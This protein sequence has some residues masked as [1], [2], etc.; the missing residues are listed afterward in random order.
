MK[1]FIPLLFCS[2]FALWSCKL[3]DTFTQTNV[4]DLVTFHEGQLIN[5]YGYPLNVVQDAVGS[6]KWQIPEARFYVIYDILN[7]QLDIYLKELVRSTIL[8]P[9]AYNEEVEYAKDPLVP[10]MAGYS[11]GYLNLGFN[12]YRAK[13]S[14]NAHPIYFYSEVKNS[15]LYIHVVHEG[16]NEDPVHMAEGDLEGQSGVFSLNL[17]NVPEYTQ[18]TLIV[19]CLETKSDGTYEII[20]ET[21][22]I[23]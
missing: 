12:Y 6:S 4:Q 11:G 20:E 3:E 7:R 16:N 9:L 23:K 8:E 5:D 2:L 10:V 19:Q 14:N 15:H 18:T 21:Y 17:K 13:N 22:D 1:K